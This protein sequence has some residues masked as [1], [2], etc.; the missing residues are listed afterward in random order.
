MESLAPYLILILGWGA[1]FF[2][3]SLLAAL[4]VKKWAYKY[5]SARTYRLFY[6]LLSTVGLFALLFVNGAH[7][8]EYFVQKS[9][10]LQLMGLILAG[11]GIFVLRAAFKQYSFSEFVGLSDGDSS[12]EFR[13]SGILS[14]VR[15]PIYTATILFSLGFLIYDPRIPTLISMIC[16]WVYLPI[17][18]YLEEKKLILRFGDAYLRYKQ[19]V[20]ALF[21]DPRKFF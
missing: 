10:E 7:G 13:R 4:R 11:A 21:P 1:Y 12:P 9:K 14:T 5:V 20:P 16:V 17:G 8:G 15:H 19:E 3:H 6:S 18:I 2:I